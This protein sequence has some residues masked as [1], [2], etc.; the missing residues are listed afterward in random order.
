MMKKFKVDPNA[1]SFAAC[2]EE[3][4]CEYYYS[5]GKWWLVDQ[6]VQSGYYCPY[7]AAL[8]PGEYGDGVCLEPIHG[9][10]QQVADF[11]DGEH[12]VEYEYKDGKFELK[13]ANCPEGFHAPDDPLEFA[14]QHG[15][16]RIY[17]ARIRNKEDEE[18]A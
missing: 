9:Q 17:P 5:A 4:Y 16:L 3:Y 6:N 8:P 7:F 18:T 14:K 15:T 2:P 1:S 13:Q 11:S 12:F 10:G